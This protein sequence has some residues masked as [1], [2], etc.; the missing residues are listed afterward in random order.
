M[1]LHHSIDRLPAGLRFVATVGVFDGLH[2]GHLAVLRGLRRFATRLGEAAPVVVTFEPH[3]DVVLR[4]A[5]P[6]LLCDPAERLARM[7]EAGMAHAVLQPFDAGFAAQ[8][9]E[10][11][12]RRLAA[13]RTLAGLV[14]TP[15]SAF[16]R[17][18]TGTLEAVEG[19]SRS[20]GFQV[21][22]V[23]PLESGGERVSSGRIRALVAAGQLAAAARL[24]GRRHAVVGQVVR[25]D[26]RGRALGF[27][28]ANLAFAAAVALPPDGIYAVR[29]SWAGPDPLHPARRAN[30]VASL[31]VR[32][33]FG[34]GERVLEVFLLD[35][36]GDLYGERLRV[37]FVRRQRGE[38]RFRDAA[39]LVAQ[40]HRDEARARAILAH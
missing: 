30:G 11:F 26:S 7:A 38:H 33:T 16:G 1:E 15:E 14:M 4:G 25:G 32:P 23:A 40:M 39:A 9:P 21:G 22:R 31:G 36:E 6:P 2:R 12:L 3:P 8:S 19:L 27:P 20:M 34:G 17:D 24:L 18:R 13:G 10:A 37:E 28:T 5:P 29:C 35:F